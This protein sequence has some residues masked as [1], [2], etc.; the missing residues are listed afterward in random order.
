MR[1]HPAAVARLQAQIT[2]AGMEAAQTGAVVGLQARFPMTDDQLAARFYQ[3]R[4]ELDDAGRLTK[5]YAAIGIDDGYVA[6]LRAARAGQLSDN[7]LNDLVGP[8][9][10]RFRLA[11]NVTAV[12]GS[13]EW[14]RLAQV[15]CE[16]ELEVLARMFERDEGDFS[17]VPAEKSVVKTALP[18]A[19]L[20]RVPLTDLFDEY[21]KSRQALGKHADGGKRWVVAIKSLV[22]NLGHSDA[23]KITKRDLNSWLD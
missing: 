12:S 1:Q 21:I 7:E 9:I 10:E 4:L 3:M 17:G 11:G 18:D 23:R 20:P 8:Q 22:K 5:G 13:R 6:T 19:P 16:A 2:K 14:R 15:L